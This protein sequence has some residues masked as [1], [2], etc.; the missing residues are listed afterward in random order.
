VCIEYDYDHYDYY[1]GDGVW[2]DDDFK[3]GK[4]GVYKY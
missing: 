4:V 3:T 1:D 2:D